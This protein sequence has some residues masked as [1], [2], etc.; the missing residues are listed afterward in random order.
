M[1]LK[2]YS[3]WAA[4]PVS[5]TAQTAKQDPKSPHITLKFKD[6]GSGGEAAINV[7]STD[8]DARLVYW[9]NQSFSHP[10]TKKLQALDLGDHQETA[11]DS[12]GTSLDYLRT[13]PALV[14]I[15]SGQILSHDVSGPNNDIL[16]KLEPILQDAIKQKAT[17]Y[18]F[19][20]SYHDSDGS[21]GIHD[22]HMNQGSPGYD[23]GVY[24]DGGFILK[25]PD[26]HWEAVFLAFASQQV[27]TDDKSGDPTSD[28]QPLDQLIEG[29]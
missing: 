23:N 15:K 10:I 18:L 8:K 20:Q 29:S 2:D 11:S 5:F 14:D 19:G 24:S 9:V 27:P 16:D 3:V 13:K 25:F 7:K 28:S 22:I 6:N 21:S 26:G 4:T 12:S 17:I 1:A